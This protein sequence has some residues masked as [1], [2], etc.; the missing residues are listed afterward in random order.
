MMEK[1]PWLTVSTSMGGPGR[2]PTFDTWMNAAPGALPKPST[3]RPASTPLTPGSL[4]G[5]PTGSALAPGT[6][7]AAGPRAVADE[8]AQK[9][10]ALAEP[11]GAAVV[12]DG[13]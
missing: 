3:S 1:Y 12:G 10:V 11:P 8:S 13:L 5:W 6:E 7:A 4:P 2:S 9:G